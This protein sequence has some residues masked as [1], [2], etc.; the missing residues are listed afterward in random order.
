M[1][2]QKNLDFLG[3]EY[4]LQ[5]RWMELFKQQ[6]FERNQRLLKWVELERLHYELQDRFTASLKKSD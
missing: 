3:F 6:E 4:E 2:S 1:K 5:D